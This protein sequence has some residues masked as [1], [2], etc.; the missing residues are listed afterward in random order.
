MPD[1]R[2]LAYTE[3]G[4]PNGKAVLYFHGMPGSRLLCPDEKATAAAGVRLIVP[5]RPGIGR[6]DPMEGRT[7]A[8][9]PK[10]VEALADALAISTVPVIGLS[11]GGSY[12]A[13]CAALIPERLSAVAI[14]SSRVVAKYNWA[15]RPRAAEAW[16]AAQRAQFELARQDPRA[17]AQLAADDFADELHELDERPEVLHAELSQ[18]EGDRWFF[19]DP[20]RV[21]MFNAH[22]RECW[23]QGPDAIK[24]E[25]I[26]V[27]Q[28]WGFRLADISMPVSIWH[29][30]Q[31]P[32][33]TKADIEFQATTIQNASL[34]VWPDAGH[35]GFAKHWAEL[36]DAVV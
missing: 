15:E 7:L 3:W 18:A 29:G 10:D 22:I 24:W 5:D 34:V 13:A 11:A 12:A 20:A 17:A 1:G 14:V 4:H 23:R 25:L 27:F 32:W 19:E 31:D 30:S 6:S 21:A 36:L 35:V 16:S 28:P 33:V 2:Q 26:D 9:W 8:D